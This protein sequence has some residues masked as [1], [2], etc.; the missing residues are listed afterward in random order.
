MIQYYLRIAYD[1]HDTTF[2]HADDGNVSTAA[3]DE[4]AARAAPFTFPSRERGKG[5]VGTCF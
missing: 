2:L 3:A 4:A 1:D 5:P